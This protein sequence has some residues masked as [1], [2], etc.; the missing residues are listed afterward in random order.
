MGS[1]SRL[2]GVDGEA[3]FRMDEAMLVTVRG[4]KVR[5]GCIRRERKKT[6]ST[7]RKDQ[8]YHAADA[9]TSP[10]SFGG[11]CMAV[12]LPSSDGSTR[13]KRAS[14][15]G[16]PRTQSYTLKEASSHF[17]MLEDDRAY[18][19]HHRVPCTSIPLVARS[20]SLSSLCRRH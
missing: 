3:V 8:N 17:L 10:S 19:A 14:M 18:L 4:N 9:K 6:P 1:G 2:R 15:G 11:S 13:L 7:R 16:A 20:S 12:S 5:K